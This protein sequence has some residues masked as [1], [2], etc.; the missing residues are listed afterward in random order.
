MFYV[1]IDDD[2]DDVDVDRT[3][4]I[5][6]TWLLFHIIYLL[7]DRWVFISKKYVEE[8][9]PIVGAFVVKVIGERILYDLSLSS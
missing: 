7:F 6:R 4:P 2:D 3:P 8:N 1:L 9:N 5:S